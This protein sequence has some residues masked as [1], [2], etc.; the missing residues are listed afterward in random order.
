MSGGIFTGGSCR[1][2]RG[3]WRQGRKFGLGASAVELHPTIADIEVS[4]AGVGIWRK[5][6][7][8]DELFV[9]RTWSNEVGHYY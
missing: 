4:T 6:I 5:D 2:K 1:Q 9:N 8:Q 7:R 3:G